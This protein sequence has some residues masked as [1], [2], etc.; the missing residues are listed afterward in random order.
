MCIPLNSNQLGP[1][2]DSKT[3]G[4]QNGCEYFA[5]TS[6]CENSVPIE[7]PILPFSTLPPPVMVP[8]KHT[9]EKK[10]IKNRVCLL[11]SS[12]SPKFGT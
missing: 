5:L 12:Q 8:V 1:I 10:K 6:T 7:E 11:L 4:K 3:S 9:Q 2:F